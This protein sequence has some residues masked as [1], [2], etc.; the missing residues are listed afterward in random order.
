MFLTQNHNYV[1]GGKKKAEKSA[2]YVQLLWACSSSHW[3]KQLTVHLGRSSKMHPSSRTVHIK[4]LHA[5][6]P[7]LISVSRHMLS[8]LLIQ[9]WAWLSQCFKPKQLFMVFLFI[10]KYTFRFPMHI[11]V[12]EAL[13]FIGSIIQNSSTNNPFYCRSNTQR[14]CVPNTLIKTPKC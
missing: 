8:R 6:S 11:W 5:F 12:C 3:Q 4:T 10:N 9:L 14:S 7:F 13:T 2:C 1:A